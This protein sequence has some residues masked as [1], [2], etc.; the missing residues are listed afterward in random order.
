MDIDGLEN[1][2][3]RL[4]QA[5]VDKVNPGQRVRIAAELREVTLRLLDA[6]HAERERVEAENERLQTILDGSFRGRCK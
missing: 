3:A 5:L 1:E 2:R 6:T 4:Q